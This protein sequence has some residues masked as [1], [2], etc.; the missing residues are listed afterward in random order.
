MCNVGTRFTTPETIKAVESRRRILLYRIYSTRGRY[1]H[2]THAP[3][4]I[5]PPLVRLER[6]LNCRNSSVDSR[7]RR[8]STLSPAAFMNEKATNRKGI[9]EFHFPEVPAS[10]SFPPSDF[11]YPA[12]IS[13]FP[14]PTMYPRKESPVCATQRR[15]IAE[16]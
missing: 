13:I 16:I 14:A 5:L 2:G 12:L 15:E 8:V 9:L 3:S 4:S 10:R 1:K 11:H 7:K 6:D